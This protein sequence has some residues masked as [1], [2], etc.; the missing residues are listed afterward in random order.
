[1]AATTSRH[2][3]TKLDIGTVL[4][5]VLAWYFSSKATNLYDDLRTSR[6]VHEFLLLFP[7]VLIQGGVLIVA[8][9]MLNDH[10]FA[11][12]FVMYYIA[13]L[14]VL[15]SVK[16]YVSKKLVQYFRMSGKNLKIYLL[17]VPMK[18]ECL[19]IIC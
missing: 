6:Y 3:F 4:F 2:G 19:F 17:L 9:F 13:I 11:R 12:T 14:L 8:L 16:K 5:L 10:Y 18:R 1:M 15:I 7:N